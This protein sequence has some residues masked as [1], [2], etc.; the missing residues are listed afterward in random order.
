MSN[1]VQKTKKLDYSVYF[2]SLI[3]TVAAPNLLA[4]IGM[5]NVATL[6]IFFSLNLAICIS[7]Y[8]AGQYRV[9]WLVWAVSCVL[10]L[11]LLSFPDP[12][13]ALVKLLPAVAASIF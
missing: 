7:G 6:L 11:V 10:A 12:L 13:S 8:I 4:A 1:V 9:F 2:I 3:L 5:S